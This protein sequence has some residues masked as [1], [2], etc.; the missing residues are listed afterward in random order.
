V[1]H[2]VEHVAVPAI[3]AALANLGFGRHHVY[4]VQP[5]ANLARSSN[6]QV[7]IGSSDDLDTIA[8]LAHIEIRHRG[9]PPIYAPPDRRALE[10]ILQ[11]HRTLLDRGATHFIAA[12][13][14]QD[15]GLLTLERESPAPRLCAS[16]QPYIGPTATHPDARRRGVGAA[17]VSSALAWAYDNGYESVSLDFEPAN[18]LSRPFWL[19]TGFRPVGYG[20]LRT[21]HS[22][23]AT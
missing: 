21:L 19:G 12:V 17:L 20:V 3:D 4:A 22:G 23:Y 6:V 1:Q 8:R 7:R 11:L 13:D 14:G 18:P 15:V 2:F 10:D 16:G 9:T 5:V